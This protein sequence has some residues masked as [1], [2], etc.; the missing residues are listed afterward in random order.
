MSEAV[1]DRQFERAARLH[2]MRSDLE[3]L[4]DRLLPRPHEE[5]RS[6]VYPVSRG[7]R[8]AWMLVV[9]GTV[10]AVSHE[11]RTT[12][13]ASRWL[14]RIGKLA[15]ASNS[16]LEERDATETRIVRAWFRRHPGELQRVIDFD[17]VREICRSTIAGQ[18]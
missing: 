12:R 2:E 15:A 5:P 16:P 13:S 17:R 6:F 14:E 10:L 11:P 7:R 9:R 8:T 1:A 4:R 18:V 3:A